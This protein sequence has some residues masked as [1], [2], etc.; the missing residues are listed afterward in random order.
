MY[1]ITKSNNTIVIDDGKQKWAFP[2]GSL[3]VHANAGDNQ[4][5]DIKLKASRKL[6]MSFKYTEC[7]LA[8]S[9][10]EQTAIEIGKLI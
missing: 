10:A 6:I 2:Q 3:V 7:N 8:Q 9:D 5:V 1:N 4:S